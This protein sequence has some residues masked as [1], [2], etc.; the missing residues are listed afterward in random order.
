MERAQELSVAVRR[1]VGFR[2]CPA[3]PSCH[4]CVRGPGARLAAT[5]GAA[6]WR[7]S[8][9]AV[10]EFADG[11]EGRSEATSAAVLL[12]VPAGR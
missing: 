11:A 10:G 9:V 7:G 1:L 6:S 3:C 4:L 2:G 12:A 8:L 5:A